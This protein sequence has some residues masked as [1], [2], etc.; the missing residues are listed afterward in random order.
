MQDELRHWCL[1]GAPYELLSVF[2]TKDR[3]MKHYWYCFKCGGYESAESEIK[4]SKEKGNGKEYRGA[5]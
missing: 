2:A 3:A 1:C 4:K 5:L